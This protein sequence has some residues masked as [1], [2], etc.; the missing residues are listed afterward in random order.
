[1]ENQWEN[2]RESVSYLKGSIMSRQLRKNGK[3]NI[4]L[5]CMAKGTV[6][7]EHTSSREGFIYVLD[8]NGMFILEG[9]EIEMVPGIAIFMK[10]GAGHS[11]KAKEN[12]AFV[13]VLG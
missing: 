2:L 7:S 5:F 12:T 9:K 11:L 13:L 4:T 3:L 1:M 6:L 8:G 10:K